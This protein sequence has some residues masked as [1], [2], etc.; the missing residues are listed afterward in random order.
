VVV[1]VPKQ[2]LLVQELSTAAGGGI[3][4]G[5]IGAAA[6]HAAVQRVLHSCC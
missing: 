5:W 4:I 2:M 1:E 6:L 3:D